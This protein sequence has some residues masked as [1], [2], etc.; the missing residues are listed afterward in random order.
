MLDWLRS[1]VNVGSPFAGV[2]AEEPNVVISS[3]VSVATCLRA[4]ASTTLVK[5]PTSDISNYF[6]QM[7]NFR[8]AQRDNGYDSSEYEE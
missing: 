2:E 3:G 4:G 7:S 6:L 5:E 1:F 8:S